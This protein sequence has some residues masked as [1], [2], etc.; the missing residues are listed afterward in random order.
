MKFVV[1]PNRPD[2]TRKKRVF[3]YALGFFLLA[4]GFGLG[5]L[6]NR[7]RL[8]GLENLNER[9][10]TQETDYMLENQAL[11]T[12]LSKSQRKEQVN[13]EA[14][15]FLNKELKTLQKSLNDSHTELHFFNTLMSDASHKSGL[16]I[17]SASLKAS[18]NKA[19]IFNY[20]ITLRQ[21][22]KKA[23]T[24]QGTLVL[25]ISGSTDQV[26]Q[27]VDWPDENAEAIQFEFKYFQVLEGQF[28]L[29]ENF[30]PEMLRIVVDPSGQGRKNVV[31][32][33]FNWADLFKDQPETFQEAEA[34]HVQEH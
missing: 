29:P 6:H 23:Q 26:V 1:K 14:L 12:A 7:N 4:G 20:A 34:S 33:T 19:D 13:R 9:L 10:Q 32:T 2:L 8:I 22:L 3:W 18:K 25:F 15:F 16:G 17:Y 30:I 21:N 11:K 24:I 27:T 5:Q 28:A 31:E